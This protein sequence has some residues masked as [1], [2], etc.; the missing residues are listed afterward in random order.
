[1][2]DEICFWG[3]R[4]YWTLRGWRRIAFPVSFI[5]VPSINHAGPKFVN[6]I[7]LLINLTDRNLLLRARLY[8]T[9][10]GWCDFSEL[11]PAGSPGGR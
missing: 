9:L 8:R 2:T 10:R 5:A 1:M 4:L 11:K 6:K 7:I 3:A